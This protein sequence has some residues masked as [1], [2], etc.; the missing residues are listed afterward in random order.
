MM[1]RLHAGKPLHL[2]DVASAA[3][4]SLTGS[5]LTILD[6]P[7]VPLLIQMQPLRSL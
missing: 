2:C 5:T 1:A 4:N 7:P 3:V 6:G